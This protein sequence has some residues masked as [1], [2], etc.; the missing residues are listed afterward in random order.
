[1]SNLQESNSRISAE[2]LLSY[3][4]HRES[5]VLFAMISFGIIGSILCFSSA[6]TK[7][8]YSSHN[9]DIFDDALIPTSLDKPILVQGEKRVG[10][11]LAFEIKA[12]ES[13]SPLYMDYGDGEIKRIYNSKTVFYNYSFPGEYQLNLFTVEKNQKKVISSEKIVI[14]TDNSQLSILK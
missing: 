8:S 7:S 12:S 10:E 4:G 14:S 6:I 1:M 2:R 13:N 9:L 3:F 11:Q 5:L